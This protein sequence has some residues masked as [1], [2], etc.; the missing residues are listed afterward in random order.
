M[1]AAAAVATVASLDIPTLIADLRS[2]NW[3]PSTPPPKIQ[4]IDLPRIGYKIGVGEDEIH[5]VL[6]VE[7]PNGGYRKSG[8]MEML[9]EPHV[10]YRCSS[11]AV[12]EK[13]V[14][15]GL[16]YPKW[17]EKPYGDSYAKFTAAYAIS[18][19]VAIKACS[20]GRGQLLG[21]N[22]VSCG[23]PSPQAMYVTMCLGGEVEHL[24]AMVRF[25]KA[26]NLDDELRKHNWAGFARGYNGPQYAKNKYDTKLAA[27]YAWW[28]AR[29]DTPWTPE[30]VNADNENRP[31]NTDVEPLPPAPTVTAPEPAAP[32]PVTTVTLSLERGY[33]GALT[34][35]VSWSAGVVA[36]S[37]KSGAPRSGRVVAGSRQ[38][39]IGTWSLHVDASSPSQVVVAV[40]AG[41]ALTKSK[42]WICIGRVELS[43]N[44]VLEGSS[45]VQVAGTSSVSPTEPAVRTETPAVESGAV[46]PPIAGTSPEAITGPVVT[47]PTSK[48]GVIATV[49]RWID[50]WFYLS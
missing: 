42:T 9:Y 2:R 7:A 34:G 5:A 48:T 39:G 13:L 30:Y 28:K 36:W 24:E 14:K 29:P 47:V 26:N 45:G 40:G 37:D 46:S 41:E 38:L 11:G 1:S 32:T 21:E 27:R 15:A 8:Q 25:I 18:P 31:V 20:W 4:D 12:R 23:Y 10:A 49:G 43:F 19:E 17:G 35:R 16:A 50:D 3:V 33:L 6:D 22:H 44:A